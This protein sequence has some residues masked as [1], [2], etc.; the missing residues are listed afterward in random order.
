MRKSGFP[1][2]AYRRPNLVFPLAVHLPLRLNQMRLR[3]RMLRARVQLK[4]PLQVLWPSPQRIFFVPEFRSRHLSQLEFTTGIT[5]QVPYYRSHS[6]HIS[7]PIIFP[8]WKI[9]IHAS[10]TVN[11]PTTT[12]LYFRS[13]MSRT[14]TVTRQPLVLG[15]LAPHTHQMGR[16]PLRI[17]TRPM[18]LKSVPI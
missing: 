3:D 18:I 12:K 7:P 6:I 2:N 4:A 13:T 5:L 9:T 10:H 11:I 17:T 8:S 1:N 15:T 16:L 14:I